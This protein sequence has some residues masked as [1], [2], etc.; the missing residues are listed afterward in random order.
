MKN[1]YFTIVFVFI[2]M[3][4]VAYSLKI[5]TENNK[6]KLEL[7]LTDCRRLVIEHKPKDADVN[8][9]PGVDAEG[10][11][12]APADLNQFD[13]GD[14]LQDFS[15]SFRIDLAD[16]LTNSKTNQLKNRNS[17]KWV[18]SGVDDS[19]AKVAHIAFDSKGRLQ[20]NGKHIGNKVQD[21]IAEKCRA[22]FPNL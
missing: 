5:T 21:M 15:L 3:S 6:T 12:V 1:I 10:R 14:P 13:L 18:K 7:T 8:Y 20:I 19:E 11:A 22:K 4:C 2:V 17:N 9:Q 16:L